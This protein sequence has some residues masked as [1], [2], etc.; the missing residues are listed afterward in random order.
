VGTCEETK[1][2]VVAKSPPTATPNRTSATSRRDR[3]GSM[4]WK[5]TTA[6]NDATR[7]V[8]TCLT[9]S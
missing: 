2:A 4:G 6:V 8:P 1:T 9:R 3:A 7:V 5:V